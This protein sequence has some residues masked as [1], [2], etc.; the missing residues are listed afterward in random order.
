[1]TLEPV[2]VARVPVR[3]RAVAEISKTADLALRVLLEVGESGPVTPTML[4]RSL[5]TSRTVVHRLLATLHGRG[6]VTRQE[7]G[8]VPGPALVRLADQAQHEL[9]SQGR[10]VM[11]EL[12][13]LVGETVVLSVADGGMPSCWTRSSPTARSCA[14]SPGSVPD[15]RW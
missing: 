15:R 7:N 6:F 11:R 10:H 9:R 3:L 2:G 12:S 8:Y 13:G 1:M 5:G 4:A 14:S